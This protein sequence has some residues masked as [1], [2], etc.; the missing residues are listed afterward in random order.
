MLANAP[1]KQKTFD[2]STIQ[3]D[4]KRWPALKAYLKEA[5]A[6]KT[7]DEWTALFEKTDACVTPVLSLEESA[8]LWSGKTMNDRIPPVAPRLTRTPGIEDVQSK[9]ENVGKQAFLLPPGTHSVSILADL[10]YSA[11]ECDRL[12]REGVV[13]QYRSVPVKAKL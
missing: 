1:L 4:Q 2:K 13:E 8:V 10:G 5:F 9:Y 6:S 12:S 3:A 11:T 7:R